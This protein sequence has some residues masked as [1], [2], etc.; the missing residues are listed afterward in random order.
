MCFWCILLS[1]LIMSK[2]YLTCDQLRAILDEKLAPLQTEMRDLKAFVEEANKKYDE[3]I[4]KLQDFEV[5]SQ[6]IIAENKVLKTA[7]QDM[8]SRV[9]QLNDIGNDLEQYTRRECVE[10]QGI[11]QS[12]DENTDEIILKVGD[13]MGLK[14]DGCKP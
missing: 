1:I 2:D 5:S 13:L 4:I 14:L 10:V 9:N 11:P 7:I 6:D 8:N 12:K 3:V